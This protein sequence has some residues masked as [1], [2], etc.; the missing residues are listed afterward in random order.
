MV[1]TWFYCQTRVQLVIKPPIAMLVRWRH[2][3]AKTDKTFT[4]DS[5]TGNEPWTRNP[6]S[7]EPSFPETTKPESPN[8]APSSIAYPLDKGN[9]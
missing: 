2:D 4:S 9:P 8:Q 1:T 7:D 3:N 5:G 6:E